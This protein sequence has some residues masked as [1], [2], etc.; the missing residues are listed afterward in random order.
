MVS[1]RDRRRNYCRLI[2]APAPRPAPKTTCYTTAMRKLRPL[3]V[4]A[5]TLALAGCA[6]LRDWSEIF[7]NLNRTLVPLTVL[8]KSSEALPPDAQRNLGSR[9]SRK[10]AS[11][12]SASAP[13]RASTTAPSSSRSPAARS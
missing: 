7:E 10:A 5:L 12:S 1:H 9:R 4:L 2:L 3:A 8:I 6:S 11:P 13:K